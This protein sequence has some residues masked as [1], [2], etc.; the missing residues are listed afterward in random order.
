MIFIVGSSRSGTTMMGDVL[1]RNARVFTF[2]ELHF[3]EQLWTPGDTGPLS[4]D[5][6]VGLA[7]RLLCVQREGYLTHGSESAYD[8]EARDVLAQPMSVDSA[9]PDALRVY[10]AVLAYETARQGAQ[11][12]CEQTPR[13]VLY[14]REILDHFPE[15]QVVNMV[16]DPRDVLLS[17]KG[18]WRRRYLGHPD[19]PLSETVRARIN[20]HPYTVSKLWRASVTA[21]RA[22]EGDPRV[23]TVRYEDLVHA[24]DETV[25]RLCD[26]LGLDYEPA[27]LAVP[28]VGS[29]DARDDTADLGI[30]ASRALRWKRGGLSSTERY[31]AQATN[32]DFIEAYRYEEDPVQPSWLKVTGAYALA[33]V[34][35]G[36]ALMANL[37]RIRNLRETLRRRLT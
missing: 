10:R 30:N 1:G 13:N 22:F 6:Q 16:R 34:Q 24:P 15:A 26:F 14:L 23:C 28:Q 18:K 8:R 33:P 27:M 3:F 4:E 32:A 7:A 5:E 31:I 17:Q 2:Q 21:A 20:Y 9:L 29:S 11:R 35:L 19:T 25:A 12:P 37:H 36:V